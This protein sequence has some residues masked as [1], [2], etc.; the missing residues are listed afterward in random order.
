MLSTT[1]RVMMQ[2]AGVH[3]KIMKQLLVFV[4]FAIAL[5]FGAIHLF[6]QAETGQVTGTIID[7]S[8]ASV[9]NAAVT[10]TNVA[11]QAMRDTVAG[12]DGLFN[13]TNLLPGDYS[14][15]ISAPGFETYKTRFTLT[16]GS[17]LGLDVKLKLGQTGTV[18]EVS[19]S[20]IAVNTETQ[21]IQQTLTTKQILELPTLSRNPMS[22][23][24]TSGNVSEDDPSGRG[25]GVAMNGLRS[26]STNIMLD[27]VSNN[28]EFSA[29]VGQSVPLDS[30]QEIGI[31]TNNFT[32][33]VGRAS[34]GIINVTVKSGTNGFHGTAYEFNRVSALGSNSFLND[35]TDVP[36]SIYDFNQFGYSL[37]GPILK[38]K[39]FFFSSTEWT[40]I[41]TAANTQAWVPDPALIAASS[42]NTQAVFSAY[43]KLASG[44]NVLGAYSRNQL[45]AAG[46]DPCSNSAAGG[47]CASYNANAPMFDLVNYNVASSF[48]GGPGSPQNT[49]STVNRVDYNISDRTQIYARYALFSESDFPGSVDNSPYNGFN[50]G[51]IFFNNS[52]I[53]S[54]TH[55]FNPTSVSQTKLDFNR[56]NNNEP[57]SSTGVVPS[58]FLGAANVGTA[59]GN[60]DVA[61]P[62]YGPF[63][64]GSAIPF[65]GPQNLAQLY[66]DFSSS[67]GKHS[68]RFGASLTYIRD[69]R[70]FGAYEE[71]NNILGNSIGT[72][73]DNF[74]AGDV[75]SFSAAVNPQGKFPCEGTVQTPACTI[76]LPVG[77][78]LFDR[79]N[80]YH[81]GAAYFQDTWKLT[82]RLT[83]NLGL[84][85]EYYGVQHNVNRNVDSNFYYPNNVQPTNPLFIQNIQQGQ[86]ETVP[87]SPIGELWKPKWTNFAPRVGIAWDVFGDGKTSLRGGYGI[88]YERNFG[89]VTFNVL[90]NPPNYAVVDLTSGSNG[91][92]TIP[93]STSN[94]G[95]L[96]GTSGSAALPPSSI[97]AIEPNIPQ[98]YAHLISASLE[99]TL[100][101]SH[102]VELDYS[103]SIGENQY[104]INYGNFPGTGNFYGGI[105]CNPADTLVPGA[106]DGC[107]ALLN[108]Q[109]SSINL[110][111]AGGHSTYNSLN[112]RYDIA[113]LHGLTLRANYTY[114]HTIDDLSD[115][116]S[117]SPNQFNL[118]YT[119]FTNPSIDKGSSNFDNRHRVSLLAIW[120]IPFGRN[121]NGVGRLLL[122]GWELAPVFSARTGAPYSIY[123]LT[124]TEYIYTRVVLDQA[125]PA[126]T[127]TAS[128][129][130]TYTLYNFSNINTGSY[131]NPLTGSSDFGPFPAN[132]T[133]RN[134]FKAPGTLD[135]DLGMYK[136]FK[137]TERLSLQL[138]LEAF[139][140]LNHANFSVNTGAA[141]ISGGAGTITGLYNGNRNVQLGAKIIF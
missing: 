25:A 34:A 60:Y 99:H 81:E 10:V 132:M 117:A 101:G 130:D 118:G 44:V 18:V 32:A 140:A 84:R 65:G 42:P 61:L 90:F 135:L 88:G 47:G 94:A 96:T 49:Y 126:A 29:S 45:I 80:R 14:V 43:G 116:F 115:T 74:I 12:A 19:E 13:V 83:V 6:G 36:K 100:F 114:S 55:T 21:T 5:C 16:V 122:G 98:A 139:N 41:R 129:A 124:N 133:G 4:W 73:L 11:T 71:A 35:A 23:V 103:A 33:E 15:S 8:G 78:P 128:G 53:V 112:V 97:R 17:K 72:G 113:N 50:T 37:G 63:T 2:E 75:Y 92:G 111:G 107:T 31:V 105:P 79:S 134:A 68:F 28:D 48:P 87:N 102:H 9:A 57:L 62:G 106:T 64:P 131:I 104:D 119:D 77:P 82:K 95:P 76:T 70:T 56:L 69:N 58:Y 66:Q 121:L 7:P 52:A 120:E 38:N 30:V 1:S 137:F 22:L 138:R 26:S 46:N 54:V 40:R 123:D 3:G 24:M 86:V 93:I 141:Y 89:N 51:Q 125:A 39:L 27:G 127:R 136:S 59:L 110:R 91:I 108:P 109:Y 85:W 67:K 20:A